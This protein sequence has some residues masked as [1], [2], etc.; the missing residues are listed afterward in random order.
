MRGLR[1]SGICVKEVKNV[2]IKIR[3]SPN[4]ECFFLFF[5]VITE[6]L[7]IFDAEIRL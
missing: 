6:F 2:L 4:Y 1:W 5:A 3:L 7:A